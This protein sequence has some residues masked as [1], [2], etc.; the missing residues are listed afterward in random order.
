M[1]SFIASG[2]RRRLYPVIS[3]L[4]LI[5]WAV[6]QKKLSARQLHGSCSGIMLFYGE[7]L[8]SEGHGEFSNKSGER[9][10]YGDDLGTGKVRT[11]VSQ[12]EE[13]ARMD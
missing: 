13:N 1:L 5:M 3:A 11:A 9:H 12:P 2:G 7:Q 6:S 8:N 10:R 4:Q